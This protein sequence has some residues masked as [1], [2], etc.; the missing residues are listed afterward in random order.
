MF[1]Y[2]PFWFFRGNLRVVSVLILPL[3]ILGILFFT[4]RLA[5]RGTKR[6]LKIAMAVV[7]VIGVVWLLSQMVVMGTQV[8]LQGCSACHRSTIIGGA[9]TQLSEFEIRDPDWVVFHL[10]EPVESI[11]KPYPTSQPMP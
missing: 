1:Y 5:K 11:L 8:P 4:P 9:P 10:Q 6:T 3:V 7:G 2:L